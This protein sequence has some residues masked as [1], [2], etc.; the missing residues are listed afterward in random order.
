VKWP[1]GVAARSGNEMAQ[2][3]WYPFLTQATDQSSTACVFIRV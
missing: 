2:H 3:P 1:R